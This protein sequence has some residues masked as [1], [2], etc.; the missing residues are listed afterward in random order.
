M[1]TGFL[2][3]MGNFV[4]GRVSGFPEGQMSV[5]P[6]SLATH[7]IHVICW[8]SLVSGITAVT[9]TYLTAPV[10]RSQLT[11]F[12]NKVRPMGFWKGLDSDYAPSQ[13]LLVSATYWLLGTLAVYLLLFGMGYVLRTNWVVGASMLVAGGAML[14]VMVKGMERTSN[15]HETRRVDERGKA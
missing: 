5:L 12:V 14:Y 9:V 10:E 4:V 15:D 2:L 7:P 6:T 8:I 3:A 13:R 11:S 1:L